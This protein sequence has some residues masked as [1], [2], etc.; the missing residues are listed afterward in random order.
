MDSAAH[1]MTAAQSIVDEYRATGLVN[2]A[3]AVGWI[4]A[5]LMPSFI[6]AEEE[7]DAFYR[8]QERETYCFDDQ[9]VAY[10]TAVRSAINSLIENL[11]TNT[12]TPKARVGLEVQRFWPLEGRYNR[13]SPEAKAMLFPVA[14]SSLGRHLQP[15]VLEF[16]KGCRPIYLPL[17]EADRLPLNYDQALGRIAVEH[18]EYALDAAG[19]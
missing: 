6:Q 13:L 11:N 4:P 19:H 3:E 16:L 14:E 17:T 15:A 1:H 12:F 8:E 7:L 5:K 10:I 2:T 9:A 18:L